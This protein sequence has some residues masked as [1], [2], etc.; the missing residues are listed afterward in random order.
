M[1]SNAKEVSKNDIIGIIMNHDLTNRQT[2]NNKI[3]YLE[4]KG[5]IQPINQLN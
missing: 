4:E 3:R 1:Y 2:I 5:Y